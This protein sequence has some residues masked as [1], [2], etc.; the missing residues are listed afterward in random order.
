MTVHCS[1]LVSLK[2]QKLKNIKKLV[3]EGKRNK[4]LLLIVC[5]DNVNIWIK[6]Y[7]WNVVRVISLSSSK[8]T[9][10]FPSKKKADIYTI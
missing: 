3:G 7:I 2:D 5:N 4:Q 6:K 10:K 8:N 9:K 1:F